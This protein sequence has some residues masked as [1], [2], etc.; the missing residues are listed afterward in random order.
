[1][2][3]T[4]KL[5]KGDGVCL[6]QS[7]CNDD[8]YYVN[9]ESCCDSIHCPTC[10][11]FIPLYLVE[12][13]SINKECTDC[14]LYKLKYGKNWIPGDCYICSKTMSELENKKKSVSNIKSGE[15]LIEKHN[16]ISKDGGR[17]FYWNEKKYHLKC[18]LKN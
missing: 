6:F 3:D 17:I 7:K 12:D 5:C 10:E 14:M 4:K 9:K 1:M 11:I 15:Y 13:N 18:W 16:C 8:N 2:T